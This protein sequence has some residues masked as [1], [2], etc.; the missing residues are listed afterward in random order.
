MTILIN[1]LSILAIL[2]VAIPL[3]VFSAVRRNSVFDRI[4]TV[5]V[6]TGF[7]MPSFW[8]ALLLMD[9]L[10]VQVRAV[11]DRRAEIDR[12]TNISASSARVWDVIHHLMLPVFVSAFGGLA[13]FS[14]YMRSN[15]LEV[16][17]QDYILTAR[18]K[19]LPETQVIYRHAL[20][21]A[22]LPVITILGLSVPGLIG[23]SVI[24]ETIF[25]IPG[26]GKLFYDGVMMR[27]YPLI[28]GI[29]VIGAVLTLVGNLLA[30]IGYA[31]ADPRIRRA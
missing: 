11:S 14:R 6:F 31:L 12:S 26:M 7:A 22:L 30:D 21:N 9:Y 2:V 23:G 25:A 16:I 5:L 8:L 18:A 4:T 29:L 24:F 13:G 1:V 28:M 20:R 17:R 19:G 15:M 27:D 3:G 10:G